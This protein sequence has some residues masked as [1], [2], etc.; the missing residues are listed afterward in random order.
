M[1]RQ[2]I[3]FP[4]A[5]QRF[6]A[7]THLTSGVD[8]RGTFPS[9]LAIQRSVRKVPLLLKNEFEDHRRCNLAHH[10]QNGAL[11]KSAI[12]GVGGNGVV[13]EQILKG[14]KYAIKWVSYINYRYIFVQWVGS[15]VA[16]KSICPPTFTSTLDKV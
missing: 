12:I 13:L 5:L 1:F 3:L 2:H 16:I 9:P 15:T 14:R 8:C 11:H 6:T 7:D 4:H 10:G